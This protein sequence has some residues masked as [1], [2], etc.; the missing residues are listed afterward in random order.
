MKPYSETFRFIEPEDCLGCEN[1]MEVLDLLFKDMEEVPYDME[2][3]LT[4]EAGYDTGYG[5]Y[6]TYNTKTKELLVTLEG[7][8]E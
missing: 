5:F 1:G 4:Y 8:C 7:A 6:Y 3:W 2:N